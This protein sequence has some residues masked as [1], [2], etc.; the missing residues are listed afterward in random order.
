M[1]W[2][3]SSKFARR[4]SVGWIRGWVRGLTLPTAVFLGRQAL[5]DRG[6]GPETGAR[7]EDHRGRS[8]HRVAAG[9]DPVLRCLAGFLLDHEDRKSTRLNSSHS[10]NSYA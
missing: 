1:P 6:R 9:V 5:V 7:G 8:R 3:T 10:S 4:T 2:M